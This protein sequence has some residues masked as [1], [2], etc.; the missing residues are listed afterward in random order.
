MALREEPGKL[1]VT[2]HGTELEQ[3]IAFRRVE[4]NLAPK[5]RQQYLPHS[6]RHVAG[7]DHPISEGFSL[8]TKLV[9]Q[10]CRRGEQFS[11]PRVTGLLGWIETFSGPM[12]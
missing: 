4:E 9:Y 3:K 5:E 2:R 11:S 8:R 6:F 12:P 10:Q 7:I 1:L